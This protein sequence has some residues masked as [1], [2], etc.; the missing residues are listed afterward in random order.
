[1]LTGKECRTKAAYALMRWAE[2]T[3]VATSAIPTLETDK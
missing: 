3:D 1:M 2:A